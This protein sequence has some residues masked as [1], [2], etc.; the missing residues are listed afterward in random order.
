MKKKELC[1]V[2]CLF[3]LAGCSDPASDEI[4]IVKNLFPVQFSVQ[5]QKEVLPFSST[6]SMP[7]NTVPEPTVP[8]GNNP[9]K[10]LK[11]LCSAIEY[12]VY[13][14]GDQ[15]ELVKHRTYHA[16]TEPDFG[17]VYD[18]L[19][20]G[21]YQIY[22]LAH[23]SQKATFSENAFSFD[24]LSD[25]FYNGQELQLKEG[26]ETNV[27]INLQRIVSRIEFKAADKIPEDIVRFEQAVSNHPDRLDI[28]T[29]KGIVSSGPNDFSYE[30]KTEEKGQSGKIH[31]FYS[32]I[33]TGDEKI[34]VT[35][36]ATGPDN[37]I[38]RK[39]T[40]ADI[41][42]IANKIIRYTGILYTPP[43]PDE[44]ENTFNLIIGNNG[45]W[46]EPEENELPE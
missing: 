30:F 27:D 14:K 33:P 35:L 4:E 38:L 15:L 20:A 26:D 22:L 36:T 16:N 43:K 23:Q 1:A 29:G 9:D 17:I 37:Q 32:F 45:E 8:D 42:P 44:T 40:V 7:P 2:A 18:T 21:N 46:D 3:W 12:L 34:S 25:S 24:E 41:I 28:L 19:P 31:S 11:E 5:L 13:K 39:R 6:R 10:E